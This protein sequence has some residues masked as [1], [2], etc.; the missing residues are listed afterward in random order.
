[1]DAAAQARYRKRRAQTTA[2]QLRADAVDEARVA[3]WIASRELSEAKGPAATD[4][5][6]ALRARLRDRLAA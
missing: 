1:M 3:R 5:M 6:A 4:R 2:E